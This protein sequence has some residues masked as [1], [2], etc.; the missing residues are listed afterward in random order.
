MSHFPDFVNKFIKP[1]LAYK[2]SRFTGGQLCNYLQQWKILT[3]DQN[4]LQIVEGD[5]I[6]FINAAP[7]RSLCP[8]NFILLENHTQICQE[9]TS[10]VNKKVIIE[11]SHETG[12]FLSPIFSVPKKDNQ[13]R[14]ILNLKSL[15][16]HV[17]YSHF[18]MDSIE[19]VMNLV[20]KGCW[21]ASIDLKDAIQTTRT[22][23]P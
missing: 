20:M 16:E 11:T 5:Q 13:V 15:N 21:I 18:K 14:L 23:V 4:I 10:L 22:S 3:S 2:V 1:Y 7:K 9:I 19:T 17:A 6:D 12:E 8:K